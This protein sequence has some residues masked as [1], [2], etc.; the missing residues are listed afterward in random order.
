MSDLTEAGSAC[1]APEEAGSWV[2]EGDWTVIRAAELRP[3][4][5]QRIGAGVTRIDLSRITE[6]DSAGLQLLLSA[7]RSAAS[8]GQELAFDAPSAAVRA[9]GAVY[10]LDASLQAVGAGS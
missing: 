1:E 8:R 7:Q 9:L 10:R 5:A 6:F 3:L 4:L 2:P